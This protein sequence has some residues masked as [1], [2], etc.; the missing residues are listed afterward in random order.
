MCVLHTENVDRALVSSG[1]LDSSAWV[2]IDGSVLDKQ[3]R[4]A[5]VERTVF[6]QFVLTANRQPQAIL[7][8]Q[9]G[10]SVSVV[11][12]RLVVGEAH[13]DRPG[14]VI[15]MDRTYTHTPCILE[16]L[17]STLELRPGIA[18]DCQIPDFRPASPCRVSKQCP[19]W[20][21][22]MFYSDRRG[23]GH[24]DIQA[25]VAVCRDRLRKGYGPCNVVTDRGPV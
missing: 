2:L 7:V 4:V 24:F 20:I 8:G 9:P 15:A 18:H 16:V 10:G 13:L 1:Q 14:I 5:E 3:M 21:Q 23:I 12:R 22:A 11:D 17:G 19:A 6:R 25:N